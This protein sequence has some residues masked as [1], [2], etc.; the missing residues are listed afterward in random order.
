MNNR[1]DFRVVT[2]PED[3]NAMELIHERVEESAAA[4]CVKLWILLPEQDSACC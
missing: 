3:G 4:R 1:T 2:R